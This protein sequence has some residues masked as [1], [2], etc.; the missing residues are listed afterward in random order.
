MIRNV[1]AV[2]C[3]SASIDQGTNALSLFELIEELE[4]ITNAP[5]LPAILPLQMCA[6]S[7]WTR[8]EPSEPAKAQVRVCI[9]APDG[10][11]CIP[12]LPQIVDLTNH[13]RGRLV[14][15]IGGLSYKGEGTYECGVETEAA[16]GDWAE[17]ARVPFDLRVTVQPPPNEMQSS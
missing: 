2:L 17:V 10:S 7:G 11:D 15:K 9:F 3:R 16:R 12:L 1:W 13:E 8:A 14:A 4:C 6:V 5:E